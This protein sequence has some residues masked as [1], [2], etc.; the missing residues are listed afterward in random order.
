MKWSTEAKVGAFTLVGLVAFTIVIAQLSDLVLFGKPGYEIQGIFREANGLSKGHFIRYSGVEV[1]RVEGIRALNRDV[2]VTMKIYE[3]T[4]IPKDSL[5]S[6]ESEGILAERYVNIVP[7]RDIDHPLQPGELVYGVEP[8]GID[9]VVRETKE[10]IETSRKTVDMVNSIIGDPETQASLKATVKNAEAVTAQMLVLADTAQSMAN[11]V[12]AMLQRLDGDG[13]TTANIRETAANVRAASEDAR[14]LSNRIRTMSE[15]IYSDGDV[16]W[17]YNT[18][19]EKGALNANWQIHSGD[20]FVR[21]GGEDIGNGS[22]L[23]FQYG[24]QWGKW[25]GR[26]GV[27]RGE[28]GV[29]VD[30]SHNRWKFTVDAFD[31]DDMKYR[32]RGQWKFRENWNL[33][34][35]TIYPENTPYGG[36]YLGLRHDF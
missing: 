21:I 30:Y 7:G 18:D 15:R 23:N 11:E 33:V 22:N 31:F 32:V 19:K 14:V 36:A 8:G 25:T 26:A 6:I 9:A 28:A 1:G 24:N 20:S 4:K 29:G 10:L 35:Q 2:E 3:D 16:E 17:L 13:Q 34:G 27:I 5:F 12:E